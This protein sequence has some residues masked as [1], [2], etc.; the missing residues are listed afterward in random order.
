MTAPPYQFSI[1]IPPDAE[2]GHYPI[3]AMGIPAAGGDAIFSPGIEVDIER[4][5][6]PREV[7][8]Q[9]RSVNFGC[10]REKLPL[11]AIG[12]FS[13]GS[14]VD[15]NRSTYIA[16]SSDTPNVA[17]VDWEGWVTSVA[18]GNARITVT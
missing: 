12:T 4:P 14:R 9:G 6:S 18:P 10:A 15:L 3:A 7:Q 8:N 11:A 1:P 17:T 2:S 5:D 16:Y 13:D